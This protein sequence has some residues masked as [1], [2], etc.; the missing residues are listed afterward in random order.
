MQFTTTFALLA[1]AAYVRAAQAATL[2]MKESWNA[3]PYASELLI[4][5][6]MHPSG[7]SDMS[8]FSYGD[9]DPYCA[10]F[11]TGEYA[12][13]ADYDNSDSYCPPVEGDD[14]TLSPN[15]LWKEITNLEADNLVEGEWLRA[16]LERR[17]AALA[18]FPGLLFRNSMCDK[19]AQ[20]LHSATPP[21][22]SNFPNRHLFLLQAHTQNQNQLI[23]ITP[24]E[25]GVQPNGVEDNELENAPGTRKETRR[26]A[27]RRKDSQNR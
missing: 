24:H 19:V 13:L 10:Y 14:K 25:G 6:T 9:T 2:W 8:L 17:L 23:D 22:E 18:E 26:D 1:F 3:K 7:V 11:N 20:P 5:F 15:D 12:G 27:Q 16:E 21:R 4:H